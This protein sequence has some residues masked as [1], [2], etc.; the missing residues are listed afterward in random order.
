MT[1]LLRSTTCCCLLLCTTMLS[2]SCPLPHTQGAHC[3][4]SLPVTAAAGWHVV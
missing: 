4:G 1:T 3:V 2:Q